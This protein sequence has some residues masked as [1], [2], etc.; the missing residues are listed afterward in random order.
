V[1]H[2][3][4][5]VGMP[6]ERATVAADQ[7]RFN[8]HAHSGLGAQPRLS[9]HKHFHEQDPGWQSFTL[10]SQRA[11]AEALR[12]RWPPPRWPSPSCAPRVSCTAPPARCCRRC[13]R[14]VAGQR[15][16]APSHEAHANWSSSATI[17]V[18]NVARILAERTG[19]D[20]I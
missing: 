16:A 6:G 15:R 20:W 11:G 13:A 1:H 17:P 10:R 2:H 9:T 4:T 7:R 8:G 12:R 3:Y 18:G 5:P 14:V 19:T